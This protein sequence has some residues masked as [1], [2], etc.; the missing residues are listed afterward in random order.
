MW[1]I[2]PSSMVILTVKSFWW[3]IGNA[4]KCQICDSLKMCAVWCLCAQAPCANAPNLTEYLLYYPSNNFACACEHTF[5][6]HCP[7]MSRFGVFYFA[8]QQICTFCDA[9]ARE[10]YFRDRK[11]AHASNQFSRTAHA[12]IYNYFCTCTD[13][14]NTT[15]ANVP[16]HIAKNDF[17][18]S[19]DERARWSL[20]RRQIGVENCQLCS[21][22]HV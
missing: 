14:V 22:Y 8:C 4:H 11:E 9:N 12:A 5:V 21:W 15:N 1:Q 18:R 16:R 7:W 13:A 20:R 17:K 2:V 10:A 3:H 19:L 6:T